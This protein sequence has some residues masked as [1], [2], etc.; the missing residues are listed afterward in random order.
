MRFLAILLLSISASLVSGHA[1]I[2]S[3]KPLD[4]P[5]EDPTGNAY[6]APLNPDGSDFPCKQLHKKAG[7]DMTPTES[8]AAGSSASFEYGALAAHSGGS[9]Q[10]SLSYDNG[11]T[12]SVLK[13]FHGGCPRDVTLNSNLAGPDQVFP[14]PI[15]AEA[16]AGAALFAWTWTAV[17]GNRDE[18]YM[19]CAS[20]EITGSGTSTLEDYPAMYVGDMNIPGQIATGECRSTAGTALLYPNPG[21]EV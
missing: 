3:P 16:K 14:F 13:S 12:W 5:V 8:W 7:V 18:F 9:C 1:R 19:N 21:T 4:A 15:P 20:V 10:A 11:T 6:N 2:K 17:T